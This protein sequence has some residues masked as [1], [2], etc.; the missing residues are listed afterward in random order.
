MA[1]KGI[2][3]RYK[4]TRKV[5]DSNYSVGIRR[6]TTCEVFLAWT[7]LLCPCCGYKLRTK[8]RNK[9]YKAKLREKQKNGT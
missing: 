8:P 7:G 9:T 5:G 1:C 6:C 4:Q 3:N 2:H